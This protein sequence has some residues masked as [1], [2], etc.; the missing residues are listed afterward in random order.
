MREGVGRV[1][2]CP[3]TP[4]GGGGCGRGGRR[5]VGQTAPSVPAFANRRAADTH[6]HPHAVT[7]PDADANAHPTPTPTPTP[8][9]FPSALTER[10]ISNPRLAAPPDRGD[11]RRPVGGAAAV[12][13]AVSLD[14]MARGRRR[15]PALH[16]GLCGHAAQGCRAGPRGA[17]LYF[18]Q[19]ASEWKAV[20]VPPARRERHCGG[21]G[22]AR[23]Q[24]RRVP[25]YSSYFRRVPDRFAP[26]NLYTNLADLR[27]LSAAVGAS[28]A[29]SSRNGSSPRHPLEQRPQGGSITVS[30]PANT[31]TYRYNRKA[32]TY[33]RTV[34]V[35][36]EQRDAS[37]GKQIAPKNVVVMLVNSR[38]S[39][40]ARQEP[41]GGRHHRQRQG[42]SRRTARRSRAPGRRTSRT[43]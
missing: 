19:W 1:R 41:P 37:N 5:V 26:H 8:E 33:R 40:M 4:R 43:A 29:R 9:L 2:R 11:D 28:P 25:K 22:P 14:R 3:C 6:A 32:N 27:K 39:T 23:L 35:E 13:P 24:R 18:V 10:M 7:H 21:Q 42:G 12:R 17:R 34:S 15:H 36:G 38:R 16:G 30:Y 20:Y 31:I